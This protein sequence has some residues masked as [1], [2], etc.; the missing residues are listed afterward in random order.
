MF[1]SLD[2]QEL[3]SPVEAWLLRQREPA[4]NGPPEI[5]PEYRDLMC[6]KCKRPDELACL[7]R[8]ISPDFR[9]PVLTTDAFTTDD[10]FLVLS[11]RARE[12][13]LSVR[14]L[15]ARF[16]EVPSSDWFVVYPERRFCAPCDAR[17]YTPIEPPQP[18]DAFQVRGKPCRKC[19]RIQAMTFW[20]HWF[21][22]PDDVVLA[23]AMVEVGHPGV[24]VNW[25][26]SQD[27]VDAI[28]SSQMAGWSIEAVEA[29]SGLTWD[30][31]P[32]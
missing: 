27:V 29:H 2:T 30:A 18:G 13:L 28:K 10:R 25:I 20:L 6:G 26:A 5:R 9:P 24:S 19:G 21:R 11:A 23:G 32:M 7:E 8:G 17:L 1:Y 22:V 4:P 16:Y 31:R 12:V 15:T 14:G 3:P